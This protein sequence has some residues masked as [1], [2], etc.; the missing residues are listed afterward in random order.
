MKKQLKTLIAATA[1]VAFSASCD[2][3]DIV[4]INF[5]S[6]QQSVDFTIAPASA[7][8]YYEQVEVVTTDIKKQIEDN[9][10]SIDNLKSI[11]VS[12]LSIEIVSGATNLDAFKSFELKITATGAA[13]KKLAWI[14][15]VPLGVTSAAPSYIT[16]DI[17]DYV[18]QDTYTIKL[19]GILRSAITN[20][21]VLRTKAHFDVKL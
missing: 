17:K 19:S 13:D 1:F 15:D 20:D 9:G 3:T 4:D 8:D 6:D 7:G 11:K 10:G 21:V 18:G 5:T 2:L 12:D 14:D 16:E